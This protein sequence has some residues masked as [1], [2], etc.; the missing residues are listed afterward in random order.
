MQTPTDLSVLLI[1]EMIP[2]YRV[3]VFDRLARTPGLC[4]TVAHSDEVGAGASTA[5]KE[6]L[7]PQRRFGAVRYQK[8]LEDLKP[9]FDV[10]VAMFDVRWMSTLRLLF[11]R[12][13]PKIVLWGQGMGRNDLINRF[14]HICAQ[15]A[16]ALLLYDEA[17]KS[18]FEWLGCAEEKMYVAPNT[19]HVEQQSIDWSAARHNFL[20][21]G[22]LQARKRV[23]LLLDAFAKARHRLPKSCR[24]VLVGAGE[25][26]ALLE[27]QARALQIEER[28]DFA[29]EVRDPVRLSRFFKNAL[30]YVSPGCVGLGVLHSFA[31]GVPVVTHPNSG[32][33]PEANNI[34]SGKNGFICAPDE[35]TEL[36]VRFTSE[37]DL[38]TR[39]GRRAYQK[40]YGER[41]VDH[42]VHGMVEAIRY[43]VDT[44][45]KQASTVL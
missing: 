1:Q 32:H 45:S 24:V 26:K 43:V 11:S 31:H 29:G 21:V 37:E 14:R 19:L 40:Y 33:G 4:L 20:F 30:A 3:D 12:H 2:P 23:D 35:L 18:E 22:R 9:A 44:R 41:T 38:S 36:L 39:L 10:V 27:E 5:Y 34:S 8:G 16:D 6:A 17:A 15:R 7:L 42:M 25:Q 13:R 28:V